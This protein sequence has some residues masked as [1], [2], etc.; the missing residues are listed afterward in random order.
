ML[1]GGN[2][3]NDPKFSYQNGNEHEEAEKITSSKNKLFGN[4]AKLKYF[5][6]KLKNQDYI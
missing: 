3:V 2:A 6:V 5:A 1:N 4:M